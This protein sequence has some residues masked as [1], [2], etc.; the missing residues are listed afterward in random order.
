MRC[1]IIIRGF[2]LKNDPQFPQIDLEPW[3][4]SSISHKVEGVTFVTGHTTTQ[5]LV[6]EGTYDAMKIREVVAHCRQDTGYL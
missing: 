3:K 6:V 5:P 4:D 1:D 2:A